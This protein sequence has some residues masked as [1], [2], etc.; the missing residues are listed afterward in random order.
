MAASP[1]VTM[2]PLS[3]FNA[4]R[5]GRLST[6]DGVE[7]EVF[8]EA[9]EDEILLAEMMRLGA[10]GAALGGW[11]GGAAT[12]TSGLSR[13]DARG[14][15]RGAARGFKWTKKDVSQQTVYLNTGIPEAAQ[16]VRRVL[17]AFGQ[18][19]GS[20][21]REDG[22]TAF[23]AVLGVGLGGLNPAVV[24]VIVREAPTGA[25]GVHVRAAGREGL[26]KQHPADKA[27]A[28]IIPLLSV[29]AP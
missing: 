20:E 22:S 18:P 15:A 13:A 1:P 16:V 12:G 24:T 26:I 4:S 10:R 27:L 19:I 7:A 11:I 5:S 28:K 8:D 2:R 23:R 9:G 14:G 21:T 3:F 6:L 25:A 29:V 17:E